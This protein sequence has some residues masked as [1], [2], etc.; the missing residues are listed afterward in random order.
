MTIQY[1]IYDAKMK[2][3][4]L[5]QKAADGE[6]IIICKAGKP[7]ARLMP[8]AEKPKKRRKGGQWKGQVWLAEDW[9]DPLQAEI[10]ESFYSSPTDYLFDLGN[11]SKKKS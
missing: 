10:L 6:E 1:N 3:S 9:D 4:E 5:V 8:L 7:I 11:P 2:L